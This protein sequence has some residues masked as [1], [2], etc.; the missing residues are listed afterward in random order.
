MK[1]VRILGFSFAAAAL[2]SWFGASEAGATAAYSKAVGKPCAFCH[3]GAPKDK[4]F[5]KDGEKFKKCVTEKKDAAK[6]KP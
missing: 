6:C 2:V 4:K 3:V 1:L 5:T